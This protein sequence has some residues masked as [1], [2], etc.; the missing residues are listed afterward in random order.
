[1]IM[2]KKCVVRSKISLLVAIFVLS[3]M[4]VSGCSSGSSTTVSATLTSIAVTP[5]NPSVAV[6]GTQ[7]F[8]ATGTYSDNS[9]AN[10]SGSVTWSSSNT[11]VANITNSGLATMG[12]AAGTT[13]IQASLGSIHGSTLLTVTGSNTTAGTVTVTPGNAA[14]TTL[15]TGSTTTTLGFN[16]PVNS[17]NTSVNVTVTQVAA[18]A[19]PASASLP[20]SCGGTS[21]LG[22]TMAAP[23]LTSFNVAVRINGTVASTITAGTTLNLAMQTGSSWADVSTITVG[24]GG[25]LNQN[26]S[27]T[28]LQGIMAPGTYV[29]YLPVSGCNTA[30][31]NLG[32]ALVTDDNGTLQ[33]ANLYDA[34]GNALPTPILTNLVYSSAYDLDGMA[35][36]PD[37]SQGIMVDGSNRILFFS[38]VQTGTPVAS[39]TV[40]DVSNYGAGTDGDSVAIMPNGNEAV[41][42]LDGS[43]QLLLVSGIASGNPQAAA[44]ITVPDY[45]DGVVISN[46]GRVLLARG[47]SGLTVFS[48][49]AITPTT[50]SLGGSVSHS[51][52]QTADI[53]TGL[54]YGPSD[55]RKGMAISPTDS[56]RA[57]VIDSGGNAALVTGLPNSA[58]AHTQIPLTGYPYSVS[59]TPDGKKAI[60]GTS[61]GILMLSGVD[62]G[63]LTQVG[64][65]SFAPTYTLNGSSTT[66]GSV[67]T[68][69]V[70]LD[71]RYAVVCDQSNSA[72]LVIPITATGFSAP[73]GILGGV[74]SPYNDQLVIH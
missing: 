55:G 64:T 38:N 44:I 25:L 16:F 7:Q 31:S 49:A 3:L 27:S 10:I 72:L 58:T 30:V 34:N 45:R 69:G 19:L 56:S 5:A 24:S 41:V 71:G 36:T 53:T 48:I 28:L 63:T 32:I 35:L 61:S 62:T 29:L 47:S 4:V 67:Y 26:L 9:T 42:S 12:S 23:G 13:T 14:T 59:I 22:F 51:F 70:T 52:T 33:V 8:T 37:G 1:M 20:G 15:N 11:S 21:L 74:T 2:K 39:S 6:N 54:G 18:S 17:V 60:V 73:V 57:V 43:N 46:D 50:G 66:L 65:T 40:I 68:L